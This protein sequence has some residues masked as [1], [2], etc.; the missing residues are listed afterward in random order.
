MLKITED[1]YKIDNIFLNVYVILF[2]SRYYFL[3][4]LFALLN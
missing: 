2:I 3:F 1:V 4:F